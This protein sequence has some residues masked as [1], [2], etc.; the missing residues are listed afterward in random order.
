MSD[1]AEV[2]GGPGEESRVEVLGYGLRNQL[3]APRREVYGI[4]RQEM[5]GELRSPRKG[6]M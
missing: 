5:V 3:M 6:R 2:A 1:G 4:T